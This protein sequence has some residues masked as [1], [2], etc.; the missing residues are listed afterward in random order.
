[1]GATVKPRF[2]TLLLVAC[3]ASPLPAQEDEI[4]ENRA[5]MSK[6][7]PSFSKDG[8][9]AFTLAAPKAS[10][11]TLTGGWDGGR[12]PMMKDD[13][14]KRTAT[15]VLRPQIFSYTFLVDGVR[16]LDPAIHPTFKPTDGAP[17][18]P[19]RREYRAE[20]PPLLF[21]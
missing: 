18:W 12:T 7:A 19:N 17:V 11:V 3:L 13:N 20:T 21:R 6:N 4:Q 5:A 2:F 1:M 16:T 10:T 15:L 9:V 8:K 14:G